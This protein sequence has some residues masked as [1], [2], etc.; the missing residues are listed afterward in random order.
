MNY[1][2][3]LAGGIGSRFWPL[4]TQEEPKQF[5]NLYS[6]R[7]MLEETLDRIGRLIK[8]KNIYVATN[9]MHSRKIKDCAKSLGIPC[10]NILFEPQGKNTLAPLGVLSKQ[11]N[12]MDPE[13][14]ILV[15]PC[16]HFIKNKI[17]FL[18][19]LKEAMDV[20][21]KGYIV[22]LGVPPSRPETGYGY[23]KI[24]S[25]LK[26]QSS[27]QGFYRVEKF[28][29]KPNLEKAKE[30][31]RDRRYYWN[32][33]IFIFK[34]AVLL[35]E[36]KRILPA[37]YKIIMEIDN[38]QTLK[39][40]WTKLPAVSIDYAIMEKTKKAALLAADYGW[41][42]LGSWGTIETVL[43]KIR[44]ATYIGVIVCRGVIKIPLSGRIINWLPHWAWRTSL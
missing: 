8:K 2:I 13:A 18:N 16:D 34:A 27:K 28:I 20:A 5:L 32:C 15:L 42:D 19:R 41:M 9:K 37:T 33:G 39:K 12:A 3:I 14:A 10:K 26:A 23:I 44:M 40:L 43:K 36:I 4:S 7:S 21:G 29:E 22:T 24:S 6:S 11:I 31:L 35:E 25:K 1:A 30:F 38:E 17:I